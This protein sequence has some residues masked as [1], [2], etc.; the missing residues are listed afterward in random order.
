ME[1][2]RGSAADNRSLQCME[3]HSTELLKED[4]HQIILWHDGQELAWDVAKR[5]APARALGRPLL[6]GPLNSAI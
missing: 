4:H 2:R 6:S 1:Q 3:H 5:M